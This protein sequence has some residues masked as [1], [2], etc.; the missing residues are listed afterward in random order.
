MP[1]LIGRWLALDW[2]DPLVVALVAAIAA[3]ALWRRWALVLLAA[4]VVALGQ[5]FD[6]LLRHA[7][8]AP[9]VAQGAVLA[10]YV[11]G[12]AFLLFLATARF[13]SKR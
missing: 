11:V 7:A 9:G 6:Y 4:L 3:I 8:L 12:A 13:V 10:I 2:H 5:G 1:D